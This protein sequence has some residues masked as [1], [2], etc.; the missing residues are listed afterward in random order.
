MKPNYA[1]IFSGEQRFPRFKYHHTLAGAAH[2]LGIPVGWV[3][4]WFHDGRLPSQSWLRAIWVR[5]EDVRS[6]WSTEKAVY[7]AFYATREPIWNPKAICEVLN[8]WAEF[9]KQMYIQL[10][11]GPKK[12]SA[13]VI[14]FPAAKK[15]TV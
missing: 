13:S 15:E 12:P 3:W 1:A 14:A 6:L 5:I 9:P 2:E 4:F 7:D 10:P 11:D 8:R